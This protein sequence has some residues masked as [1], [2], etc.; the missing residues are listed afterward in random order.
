ME[1]LWQVVLSRTWELFFI[2]YKTNEPWLN[3][4]ETKFYFINV[5]KLF[6]RFQYKNTKENYYLIFGFFIS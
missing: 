4:F 1:A 2:D 6:E 3:S 5:Y